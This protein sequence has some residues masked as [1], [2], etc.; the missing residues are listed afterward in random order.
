MAVYPMPVEIRTPETLGPYRIK[1]IL[2]QGAMG[3]VYQA[4]HETL[5]RPVALKILPK[6]LAEN[7]ELVERFL[8]EARLVA[9]LRHENIVKVYDAGSADGQH[10][11]AMELVEGTSLRK[12]LEEHGPLQEEEGLRLLRQAALGLAAAH[13]QGLVHRDIKPDNLLLDLNRN[14]RIVDFGLVLQTEGGTALTVAGACL[15][16]PQYMS[17]EQ[18]DGKKADHRTDLYSLG[19]TF[20]RALTGK[21]PFS[22]TTVMNLLFKHKFEAPPDPRSLQ[23][24]LSENTC[25]LILRLMAKRREDRPQTAQEVASLIEGL[26]QGKK[27]AP[28]WPF[29]LAAAAVST[30]GPFEQTLVQVGPA[31][32][33]GALPAAQV[34]TRDVYSAVRKV[35]YAGLGAA[36][37]LLGLGHLLWP[38][39]IGSGRPAQAQ[40]AAVRSPAVPVSGGRPA[41]EPASPEALQTGTAS[42]H[43][44]TF[45]HETAVA[46]PPEAPPVREAETVP[47]PAPGPDPMDEF[48]KRV[49]A[50][51][52]PPAPPITETPT[53]TPPPPPAAPASQDASAW[54]PDEKRSTGSREPRA[55]PRDQEE[56]NRKALERNR[57]LKKEREEEKDG[58]E[59]RGEDKG[60]NREKQ[61]D[62]GKHKGKD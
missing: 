35:R 22:G 41:P 16:T 62:R 17:P 10:Y 28:P 12:Y 56:G 50:E 34:L 49:A 55:V 23:P 19:V 52:A 27:I 20:F 21:P 1:G 18:A 43:T 36:G 42:T 24:A 53:A 5:E 61:R 40:A 51:P 8:R 26:R 2:G 6:T 44:E 54:T 31:P 29:P 15:G 37:V 57:E 25:N 45:E 9:T 60:R 39:A 13:A 33:N 48:W 47:A 30:S 7:S 58:L 3:V 32:Q 4:V 14:L 11:I 38:G 46:Q 59:E